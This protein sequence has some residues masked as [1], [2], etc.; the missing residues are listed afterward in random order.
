MPAITTPSSYIVPFTPARNAIGERRTASERFNQHRHTIKRGSRTTPYPT[1]TNV[2]DRSARRV[3]D[4]DMFED[5]Y[6]LD[7]VDANKRW[8]K[9][10]RMFVILL[11]F[12]S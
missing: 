7:L 12:F 6:L 10:C 9:R 5:L 11:T 2:Y 3:V 8:G 1:F 4:G